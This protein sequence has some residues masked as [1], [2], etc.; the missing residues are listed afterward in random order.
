M[1]RFLAKQ[2]VAR[3]QAKR[4]LV[5]IAY[6]IGVAEPVSFAVETYGT[7]RDSERNLA[8]KLA[9]EFDLRPQGIIERLKLKRP[10]YFPTA[11][12]GHFGR[13]DLDLPWETVEGR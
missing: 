1:A 11:A 9:Q 10:I 3:G 8:V 13:D 4:A 12:Y 7:G 6:A 2:L 5:Q